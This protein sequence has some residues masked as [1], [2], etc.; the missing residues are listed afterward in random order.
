MEKNKILEAARHNKSKGH[1]FENKQSISSSL[2]ASIVSTVLGIALFLIE[3]FAKGNINVS[4]I[5]VGMTAFSVQSIYKG[6]KTKSLLSIFIGAFQAI[7][8]IFAI[9]IFIWQVSL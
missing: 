1:E 6:I 7:I 5:A 4:L 9:L 2:F 8:V 3:Y